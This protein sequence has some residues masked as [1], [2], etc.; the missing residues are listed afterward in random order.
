MTTPLTTAARME[1]EIGQQAMIDWSCHSD[2]NEYDSDV[3]NDAINEGT[4]DLL[5]ELNGMYDEADLATSE[6][7]AA[8]ATTFACLCL[9]NNRGNDPPAYLEKRYER[10][11]EKLKRIRSGNG[12]IPGLAQTGNQYPSSSNLVVDRRYR[13]KTIRVRGRSSTGEQQSSLGRDWYEDADGIL[14]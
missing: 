3:V 13:D 14:E 1:R 10:I 8:W 7:V 6:M 9:C 5:F 4:E 12:N 2:A 11:L